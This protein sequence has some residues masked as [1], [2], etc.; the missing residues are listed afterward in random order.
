MDLVANTDIFPKPGETV[1]GS[2]FATV[3]GGKGGNQ[4]IA[5][6]KLGADVTMIAGIG[7]DVFG[8]ALK[9]NLE[10]CGV[11]TYG[12]TEFKG[13]SSGIATII[14]SGGE[15]RIILNKGSNYLL[16]PAVIDQNIELIKSSDALLF[17]FEI[18]METIIYAARLGKMYGKRIIVNPAPIC[19]IPKELLDLTDIIIPNEHEA[20]GIL[21]YEVTADNCK[22]AVNDLIKL[23][24][25]EAIITLGSNGS[26][27]SNGKETIKCS[28]FETK[29][30]DTTAAGDSFTAAFNLKVSEGLSPAEAL[31][32]AAVVSGIVVSRKGASTSIPSI[33]EVESIMNLPN[34][35]LPEVK[36]I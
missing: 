25:S 3:C 16:S 29:V 24:C 15:N 33:L 5:A 14:V 27:Y 12:V 10:A 26:V 2:S 35:K 7:S 22:K 32:F 8:K 1:F 28:I 17:Q 9:S 19:D 21:G 23:G 36:T 30:L 11:K 34:I 31:R 13:E 18:P 4:A 6:S 20:A